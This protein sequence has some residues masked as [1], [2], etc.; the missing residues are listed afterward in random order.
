[1]I[2]DYGGG[3]SD[4]EFLTSFLGTFLLGLAATALIHGLAFRETIVSREK[5]RLEDTHVEAG[6]AEH[7]VYDSG[8]EKQV[9]IRFK[10]GPHVSL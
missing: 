9:R 4:D 1:M 10:Q 8:G 6:R 3:L 5:A 2:N 7:D